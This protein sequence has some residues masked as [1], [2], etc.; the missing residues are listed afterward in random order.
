[1]PQFTSRWG[2]APSTGEGHSPPA[3]T[4]GAD[5]SRGGQGDQPQPPASALGTAGARCPEQSPFVRAGPRSCRLGGVQNP[6]EIGPGQAQPLNLPRKALLSC[7][8]RMKPPPLKQSCPSALGVQDPAMLGA[9]LTLWGFPRLPLLSGRA[10]RHPVPQFPHPSVEGPGRVSPAPGGA[11]KM[12]A[13]RL[14]RCHVCGAAKAMW[15]RGGRELFTARAPGAA[16]P[17]ARSPAPR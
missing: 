2:T 14:N 8:K 10:C 6:P 3:P 17:P 16:D 12:P 1:M 7:R 15:L 4:P 13:R 5:S 11:R 9:V